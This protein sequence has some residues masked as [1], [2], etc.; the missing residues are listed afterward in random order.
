ME[1]MSDLAVKKF[2]EV[3][4]LTASIKVKKQLLA[5]QR[6]D[7]NVKRFLDY[8]LNPFFVTGIS[9]KK[10]GKVVP[11]EPSTIP[12]LQYLREIFHI[13]VE[14]IPCNIYILINTIKEAVK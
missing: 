3:L 7:G 12:M 9:E 14:I 8:L 4:S 1:Q 11:K 10:I 6:S 5:D 13:N 2:F